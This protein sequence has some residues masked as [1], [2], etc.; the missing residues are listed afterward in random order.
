MARPL[1]V[2]PL[3]LDDEYDEVDPDSTGGGLGPVAPQSPKP[4]PPAAGVEVLGERPMS[5]KSPGN[6]SRLQIPEKPTT[7]VH[8]YGNSFTE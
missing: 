3:D 6:A 8:G 7:L 2:H 4:Q 5:P 1:K